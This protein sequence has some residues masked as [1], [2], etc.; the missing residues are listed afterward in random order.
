MNIKF[1]Y[2][3][4]E[5]LEKDPLVIHLPKGYKS[6][7]IFYPFVRMPDE[8]ET[9]SKKSESPHMYYPCKEDIYDFGT[10]ITWE[11]IR[12]RSGLKSI[13]EISIAI[14]AGITAGLGRKLYQR[15][16]LDQKVNDSLYKNEFYP[17]EDKISVLLIKEI[18]KVLGSNGSKKVQYAKVTEETGSYYLKD[19]TKENMFNLCT[20][21]IT[22]MDDNEE[23]VFICFFDE[24]SAIFLTK[25][26]IEKT[27][28]NTS[29]E[30]VILDDETPLVWE[31]NNYFYF[32]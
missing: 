26:N 3:L 30:G 13:A 10:P 6:A 28:K 18:I 7:I 14:N 9:V 27:L 17:M 11:E 16:D 2:P 32:N 5:D 19:I 21:P 20:E 1:F 8:W 12:K 15:L 24:A 25:E 29:F 31:E 23:F 22:L 4:G